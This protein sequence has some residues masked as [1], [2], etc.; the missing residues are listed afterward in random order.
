MDTVIDTAYLFVQ[1]VGL[2]VVDH[3]LAA[4]LLFEDSDAGG[5]TD[6]LTVVRH[7]DLTV[8]GL[9][10]D[11]FLQRSITILI[12]GIPAISKRF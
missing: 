10:A 11:T 8:P 12:C 9:T 3:F 6:A 4:P 2:R 7:L 5:E 1:M